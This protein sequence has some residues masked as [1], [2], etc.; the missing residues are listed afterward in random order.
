MNAEHI[1][2]DPYGDRLYAAD[3]LSNNSA[4]SKSFSDIDSQISDPSQAQGQLRI[5]SRYMPYHKDVSPDPQTDP[6]DRATHISAR[7]SNG[8][9]VNSVQESVSLE[10]ENPTFSP[11]LAPE[12]LHF[13]GH[14]MP[15]HQ[16][17]STRQ[18][19]ASTRQQTVHRTCT[20]PKLASR[21]AKKA[22][23]R[24]PDFS[25]K[26]ELSKSLK[27]P[28]SVH[29]SQPSIPPVSTPSQHIASYKAQKWDKARL[30]QLKSSCCMQNIVGSTSNDSPSTSFAQ[31]L[32][33]STTVLSPTSSK[34]TVKLHHREMKWLASEAETIELQNLVNT[35][36]NINHCSKPL[37]SQD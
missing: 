24:Q 9:A 29:N 12:Q 23:N 27:L 1:S 25:I 33:G 7:R 14:K 34:V 18:Q 13:S 19:K 35:A 28:H 26:A 16:K 36:H 4:Y 3:P 10:P 21:A 11:S 20:S 32:F 2:E 6:T 17:A 15:Y 22:N 31:Q 5:S 30:Q 37:A 8:K